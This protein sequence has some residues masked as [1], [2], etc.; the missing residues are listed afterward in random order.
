MSVHSPST[1]ARLLTIAPAGVALLGRLEVTQRRDMPWFEWPRD[2]DV[3]AVRRCVQAV[4]TMGSGELFNLVVSAAETFAGP[5]SGRA[6][7][8]LPALYEQAPRRRAIADAVAE[9]FGPELYRDVDLG[10]QQWWYESPHDPSYQPAPC[11]ANLS[12]V[13]GNGEFTFGGL[14]T[15][16]DPPPEV[17]D[18]LTLAW[19]YY[20]R[21][22]SRWLLRVRPDARV[23]DIDAPEDWVR[24][25]QRYPR[26]APRA[27]AGWELPGP[28]QRPSDTA[29]LRSIATQHAVRIDQALHVMPD[30]ERVAADFDGVHLS[31]AGF[32]TAEGYVS[33]MNNNSVTMLRY[34]GSERTLWLRDVFDEPEPLAAPALTG[35]IGGGVG[36]DA[37]RDVERRTSD[38]TMLHRLLG[39]SDAASNGPA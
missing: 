8:A 36:V 15:V 19:D 20:G 26:V 38:W 5:W 30:W 12:H 10:G 3:T 9:R 35:S 37:S 24:L 1:L 27:H 16:T 31:W 2:C 14:W 17:H 6:L 32:L 7:L 39:R 18:T 4:A 13:Y 34:W 22:T 23:W 21:A 33:D 28:N 29:R 25:V 11:F